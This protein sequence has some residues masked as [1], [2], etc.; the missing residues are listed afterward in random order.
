MYSRPSVS[1]HGSA[2][3]P[4]GVARGWAGLGRL[5]CGRVEGVACVRGTVLLSASQFISLL[6]PAILILTLHPQHTHQRELLP[7][8]SGWAGGLGEGYPRHSP[9]RK[10]GVLVEGCGE[11]GWEPPLSHPIAPSKAFTKNS[12]MCG[13]ASDGPLGCF[14]PGLGLQPTPNSALSA[15]TPFCTPPGGLC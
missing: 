11:D 12:A 2:H 4:P 9:G 10:N 1:S 14:R 13:N 15:W 5:G 3:G 7:G 8:P 6:A